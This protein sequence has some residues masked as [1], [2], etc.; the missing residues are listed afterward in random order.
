VSRLGAFV[1]LALVQDAGQ[2]WTD[3][4][5]KLLKK[6]A[7]EHSKLGDYL[8]GARM[9][10]WA[11]LEF[12]MAAEL[13][14]ENEHAR[15]KLQGGETENKKTGD[16]AKKVDE[17]YRKRKQKTSKQLSS[18]FTELAEWAKSQGLNAEAQLAYGRALD[19]DADN[20][21]AREAL[22][23]VKEKDKWI[24][25]WEKSIKAEFKDGS[26]RATQGA[27]DAAP[28]PVEKSVGA[29]H[30][31]R[32]TP[33]FLAESPHLTQ[34]QLSRCI[35]LA[36][37]SV[38]MYQKLF[39]LSASPIPTAKWPMNHILLK[40]KEQHEAFID[41]YDN[42]SEE[43]KKAVKNMAASTNSDPPR[44]ECWQGPRPDLFVY[45]F[46][47]HST[48]HALSS[49]HIKGARAWLRE[50]MAYYFTRLMNDSAAVHCVNFE[51]TKTE[52][53]K[54]FRDPG[55]WPAIVRDWMRAGNDPDIGAVVKVALNDLTPERTVKAWSLIDFMFAEHRDRWIEMH[56][57]L[58][59]DPK[60]TGEKALQKVFKWSLEEL[61]A[62]WKDWARSAY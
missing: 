56:K 14:P 29:T 34:V 39:N 19:Y 38:A 36:E 51:G 33:Q 6:A 25:P 20:A 2:E 41:K 17:E 22:G 55:N 46:V 15:K 62:R 47:I 44:G 7:E 61:D 49:W 11:R 50:G 45:D 26:A 30:A 1:L 16:D 35:Q 48:V 28:T 24:S 43:I 32:K 31:R 54:N 9:H 42:R 5:G 4:W 13:N 52:G 37:H 8:D 10:K 23:F 3:R 21:K 58:L 18:S 57:E 53:G 60:D 27:E 12:E 40:T 59:A